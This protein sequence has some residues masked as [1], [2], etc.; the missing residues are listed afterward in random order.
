MGGFKWVRVFHGMVATPI[1]PVDIY[2]GIL[3]FTIVQVVAAAAFYL[4]VATGL[5]AI[6]SWWAPLAIPATALGALAIGA[7]LAAY[8]ATQDNDSGFFVVMRLVIAPLFLFSGTVF[9]VDQLPAGLMPLVWLSPLYHT[10][11]LCR[12]ATTGQ[13]DPL[14]LVGNVLFLLAVI[15]VSAAVGARTF[16]RRLWA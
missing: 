14:S 5:G 4:V 3:T 6:E 15:G 9:P 12:A 8:A 13:G 16:T 2:R 11:E 7:P 1:R 10:T